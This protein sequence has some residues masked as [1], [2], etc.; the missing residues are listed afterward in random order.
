[1]TPAFQAASKS[2]LWA[3]VPTGLY[4]IVGLLVAIYATAM[5]IVGPSIYSDSGWG[6]LVGESMKQGAPFNSLRE[7]DAQ[8]IAK[9]SD[10]FI[11]AWSPG[12][13]TLPDLL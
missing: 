5:F 2:S 12:Q 3:V 1:M 4:A 7:P 8:D 6:F 9:D 10:R 11:A 13:Y